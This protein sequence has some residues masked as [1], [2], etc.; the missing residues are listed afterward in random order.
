MLAAGIIQESYSPWAHPIACV[1]K[2][3]GSSRLAVEMRCV[4]DGRQSHELLRKID[5]A[6]L[7][8]VERVERER[9]LINSLDCSSGFHQIL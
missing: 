1:A 8:N 5:K 3:D 4:P 2:P 6:R 9:S 7:I